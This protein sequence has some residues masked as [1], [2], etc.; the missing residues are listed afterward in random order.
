MTGSQRIPVR[1]MVQR[2]VDVAF[3]DLD[4]LL[5]RI[6]SSLQ[7]SRR[8]RT[9]TVQKAG[10]LPNKR[11]APLDGSLGMG[12]LGRSAHVAAQPYNG[13]HEREAAGIIGTLVNLKV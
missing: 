4:T 2:V 10:T 11:V 8:H 3:V 6:D 1:H 13:K 12:C 9:R 5:Q 7:F